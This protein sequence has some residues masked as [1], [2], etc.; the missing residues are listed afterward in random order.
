M[1][2][3]ESHPAQKALEPRIG[4]QAI[5]GWVN[6]KPHYSEGALIECPLECR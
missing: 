2:L 4:A 1:I 5:V 3:W 6:A